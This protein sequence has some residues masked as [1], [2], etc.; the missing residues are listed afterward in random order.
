MVKT[1]IVLD[2]LQKLQLRLPE[3]ITKKQELRRVNKALDLV[4]DA[5]IVDAVTDRKEKKGV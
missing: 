5:I 3:K 2:Y 4:K 1:E